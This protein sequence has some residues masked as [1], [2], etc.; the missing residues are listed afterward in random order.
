M[1]W[2]ENV[3][4]CIG[5]AKTTYTRGHGVGVWRLVVGIAPGAIFTGLIRVNMQELAGNSL[6]VKARSAQITLC[7][8][9]AWSLAIC[10]FLNA[11]DEQSLQED[12][13]GLQKRFL[14]N[15]QWTHSSCAGKTTALRLVLKS[16][17]LLSL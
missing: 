1:H 6:L 3:R 2:W 11:Q 4:L 15:A 9:I 8:F 7:G 17:R 12:S 10:R 13:F 16:S 14:Q 5:S